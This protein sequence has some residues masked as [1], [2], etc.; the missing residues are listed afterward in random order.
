M[1]QSNVAGAIA[2]NRFIYHAGGVF[3]SHGTLPTV[4]LEI[5][6]KVFSR[7]ALDSA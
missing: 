6:S 2:A 3:S 1:A 7:V 4:E 5:T